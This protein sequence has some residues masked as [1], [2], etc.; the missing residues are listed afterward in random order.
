MKKAIAITLIAGLLSA[1]GNAK[2]I[3]GKEYGTYGLFNEDSM[4]NPNIEYRIITGNV[5]WSIILIESVLFPIYFVG[6]DLYEPVGKKGDI[7]KGQVN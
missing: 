7:T 1:C 2:K 6:F 5:V 3:D 4:K